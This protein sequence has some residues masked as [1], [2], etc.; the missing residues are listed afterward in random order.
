[1]RRHTRLLARVALAAVMAGVMGAVFWLGAI[2]VWTQSSAPGGVSAGLVAWQ[3][4]NDGVSTPALW[5]D[6]G[7]SNNDAAQATAALRP[8]FVTGSAA[9]AI[10]FNPGFDFDGINDFFDYT[11]PLGIGGLADSSTLLVYRQDAAVLGVLLGDGVAGQNQFDLSMGATGTFGVFVGG[12][13]G[14]CTGNATTTLPTNQPGIGSAVRDSSNMTLRLNAGGSATVTCTANF[15]VHP[16]RLGARNGNYSN[17]T[18]A[19]VIEFNRA[20]SVSELQQAHSYLAIKYGITLSQTA[21]A[22]YVDSTSAVVWNAT[23]N[24]TYGNNIAGIGRDDTSALSQKQSRSVNTASSGN[25]VTIGLGTIAADNVSNA[26]VF[27][28]DRSFLMWGDDGASVALTV[29]VLPPTG[30]VGMRMPRTWRTQETGT[31]GTVRIGVP[32]GTGGGNAVYI[33]VSNDATFDAGDAWVPM[34]PFTPDGIAA[35]LAADADFASGQYFTFATAPLL[36]YGDAPASYGS[37]LAN[38]GA[39]HGVPGYN[40]G[41]NTAPLMLGALIDVEADGAASAAATGDDAAGLDDEDGVTFPALVSGLT[42]ILS[43]TVANTGPPAQLSAWADWNNNGIFEAGEQI[44]TNLAVM[45]GSNTIPIAVPAAAGGPTR[46]RF[47]LTTQTGL[48]PTGV[49]PDGEVEDYQVLVASVT[50]LA[51]SKTDNRTSY[52]P[53]APISYTIVVTNAGPSHAAGVSVSDIVPAAI[54]TVTTSCTATGTAGCGTNASSGNNASF[55]GASLGAGA[56]NQLTITIAGIVAPSTTGAL[57]NSV[58]VAG[59]SDPISANNSATDTDA[60][61]AGLADLQI[62]KTGP[63]SVRPGGTAIYTLTVSNAGPSEA[64][65]V[66]VTDPAP[67]GLTFVSNTGECTTPFPCDF[68]T[69]PAGSARTIVST[70][71]VPRSAAAPGPIVN[72]ASVTASTPD[73]APANNTATAVTPITASRTGCDVNGDGLDDIVTGAGPGG[74][75]HVRALSLAGGTVTELAGFHAYDPAF[76]GGVHVACGDVNGDT[77]PEI[78]TGTTQTG[79]PVRVFQIGSTGVTE[80][81]SFLAYFA[82]FQGPVRVAV[83]DVNGDGIG[84]II[85]GAGPG[86]GPHIRAFSVNG[87][88]LTELASF[89]A[90]DPGWC[91]GAFTDP[92]VCDGL[93][94]AGGDVTGDGVAE[95]ITGTNRAGGPVRVFQIGPTGI[96]EL[97]S[98]FPYIATFQGPVRVAALDLIGNPHVRDA[99]RARVV[100][101]IRAQPDARRLRLQADHRPSIRHDPPGESLLVATG[102]SPPT[103]GHHGLLCVRPPAPRAGVEHP[104]H[105]GARRL[106]CGL[107][108]H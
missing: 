15:T 25:L 44:V 12:G 40:A 80:L 18:I 97:T 83:A 5:E 32:A 90:Y 2:Q 9:G 28:A 46:V 26:S 89:Y 82:A 65:A 105:R 104:R 101:S 33:V 52:V 102:R 100:R 93:Y 69:L 98:F 14:I 62:T 4:A 16:R 36:D 56:G 86:G 42:A 19:E 23:A 45:A 85:T 94:V 11:S 84:D 67:A 29:P 72:T 81:T 30:V 70:F 35:Y 66:T 92:V 87:G 76:G 48:G 95:I 68:A 103:R 10:N 91:D 17:A 54:G 24:V 1:M 49:A 47:R 58:T 78:V 73:P 37:F 79:G 51:I 57:V 6:S 107:R 77:V 34:A 106:D 53:G 75:P 64:V 3:K 55:T 63:S 60:R 59:A 13:I 61:G 8:L 31:I 20:L 71:T 99:R 39:R 38:D 108:L 74:G 50:D 21:P 88:G 43:A 41:A 22:N 96:T 7:A 27:A